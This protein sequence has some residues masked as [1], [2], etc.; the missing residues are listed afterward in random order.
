MVCKVNLIREIH[1]GFEQK[2]TKELQKKF[3]C[4]RHSVMPIFSCR[5]YLLFLQICPYIVCSYLLGLT[6]VHDELAVDKLNNPLVNSTP[7]NS[8]SPKTGSRESGYTEKPHPA[9]GRGVRGPKIM[10]K[11]PDRN[12]SV[13]FFRARGWTRPDPPPLGCKKNSPYSLPTPPLKGVTNLE[14]K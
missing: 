13:D 3:A 7:T 11:N 4:G 14:K 5:V 1:S 6:L 8:V 12:G 2:R 9:G 10:G